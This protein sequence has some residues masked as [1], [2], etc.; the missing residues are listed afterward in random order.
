[1]TVHSIDVCDGSAGDAPLNFHGTAVAL[2]GLAVTGAGRTATWTAFDT[3]KTLARGGHLDFFGGL[4][5]VQG[6]VIAGG[7]SGL[8]TGGPLGMLILAAPWGCSPSG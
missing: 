5:S 1:M 8:L 4:A 6:A 7:V 3:P 2:S